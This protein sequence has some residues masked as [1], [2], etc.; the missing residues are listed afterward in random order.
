MSIS[1]KRNVS[2]YYGS[3]SFK[4]S[5]QFI[6]IWLNTPF[7]K[8]KVRRNNLAENIKR[9]F[10]PNTAGVYSFGSARS[11]LTSCLIAAG[12]GKGDEV[13][14][15]S[16]T[17]LAVPTGIIASGATP[18]YTDINPETLNVDAE[19]VINAFSPKV[20]AIVVQHTLG[21][22]APIKAIIDFAKVKNLYVIEDCALSPG[23]KVDNNYLGSFGDASIFSM[24]LSKTISIGWGGVLVINNNK[25]NS[26]IMNFYK[27]LPEPGW[28]SA[29]RDF[30]QTVL[31]SWA[32]HPKLYNCIGKYVIFAGFLSGFFRRSTPSHEFQGIVIPGRIFKMGGIQAGFAL[33]QWSEFNTITLA[34]R[35]N[36]KFLWNLFEDLNIPVLGKEETD[37]YQVPPRVSFLISKRNN[38][39]KY[40]LENGIDLGQWFDGPLSPVPSNPIFNYR[41][42]S[43]PSAEFVAKRIVNIPCHMRV[44]KRDIEHIRKTL[45]AY[46]NDYPDH[47]YNLK[48]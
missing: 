30:I 19:A 12:I 28:R 36:A 11:S 6:L 29:H 48:H 25:L 4:R 42:G 47:F 45:T 15:S 5:L 18:V 46:H 37:E 26:S 9:D 31:S 38:I 7:V 2:L 35:E 8:A 1:F 14:I 32:Y 33:K 22:S 24:E 3:I 10:F 34:C 17:C 20:R 16:F 21:K 43:Y 40:F 44:S 41:E 27:K 13:L 39:M 23:T